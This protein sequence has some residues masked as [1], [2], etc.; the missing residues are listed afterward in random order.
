M[1]FRHKRQ[2]GGYLSLKSYVVDYLEKICQTT[3]RLSLQLK[4]C[5]QSF[6]DRGDHHSRKNARITAFTSSACSRA[7]QCP[8]PA[9]R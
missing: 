5:C 3:A 4:S 8:A 1:T 7:T 6:A 2:T 9:M